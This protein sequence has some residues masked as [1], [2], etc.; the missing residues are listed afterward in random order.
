MTDEPVFVLDANVFIGAKN[1]YYA[2][3]I[4]PAFWEKLIEY[5]SEGRIASTIQVWEELTIGSDEL[6]E[7]VKHNFK[8]YF[9]HTDNMFVIEAYTK[10]INWV[11][12]ENYLDA[13]KEDFAKIADGWIIAYAMAHN[14]IVVTHEMPSLS[15][16]KIPMPNICEVFGVKY[17]NTFE[18]MRMLGVKL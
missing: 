13:V 17:V 3:D 11:Q 8:N 16:K 12:S 4:V 10:I 6:V 7:W 9:L 14:G 1:G 2:F 5:A 15:K 18:M